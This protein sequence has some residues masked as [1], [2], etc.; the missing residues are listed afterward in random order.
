MIRLANLE[1]TVHISSHPVASISQANQDDLISSVQAVVAI[2][3][4]EVRVLLMPFSCCERL[5]DGLL[6]FV[7]DTTC[8]ADQD[9]FPLLLG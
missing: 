1:L 4:D 9:H 7:G 3:G 5:D 8:H 6:I 2:C